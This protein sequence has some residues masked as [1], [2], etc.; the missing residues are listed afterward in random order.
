[1][2]H[3]DQTSVIA[4][5]LFADAANFNFTLKEGSPALA[6][7]FQQIDMSDVG[8]RVPFRRA[9]EASRW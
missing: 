6:L 2:R 7:G 8:I 3:R 5:P 4:D 9:P 1:M